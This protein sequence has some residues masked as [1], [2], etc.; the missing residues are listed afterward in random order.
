MV[1][2]RLLGVADA[3]GLT[4]NGEPSREVLELAQEA[5]GRDEVERQRRSRD[6]A[7]HRAVS[8]DEPSD[9]STPRRRRP[10]GEDG[11]RAAHDRTRPAAPEDHRAGQAELRRGVR[12]RASR[13]LRGMWRGARRRIAVRSLPSLH[14]ALRHA[15]DALPA[16]LLLMARSL[17]ESPAPFG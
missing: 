6:R 9:P 13:V 14:R 8:D 15:G 17:V 7:A 12:S 11:A 5:C 10:H 1:E 16:E 4:V 2:A 3:C